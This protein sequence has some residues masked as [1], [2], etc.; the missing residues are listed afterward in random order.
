MTQVKNGANNEG[1]TKNKTFHVFSL[2]VFFMLGGFLAANQILVQNIALA[3]G[4]TKQQMGLMI[5]ALFT[6]STLAVLFIGELGHRMGKRQAAGLTSLAVAAGSIVILLANNLLLVTAGFFI[7][8]SGVGGYESTV[9]SLAADNQGTGA[10]RSLN[11]LQSLFS[12]GAVLTPLLLALLLK[13]S[14]YRPLY[15]AS[16]LFYL[17]STLFYLFYRKID[18]FAVEGIPRKGL[19]F[20]HLVKDPRMILLM[21]AMFIH[22][23]SETALTYWIGSYYASVGLSDLA[24][25]SLSV[26]WF[27]SIVGRLLA[28]RFHSPARIIAPAY[29]LAAGGTALLV[30]LPSA[31]LKLLAMALVGIGF[32]PVY[33]GLTLIGSGLYPTDTAPVF[34]LMVFSA[35]LGGVAFQPLM[36][37][38]VL[39]GNPQGAYWTIAALCAVM[40]ALLA[41]QR[42]KA[43]ESKA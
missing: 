25:L 10:N 1:L 27:S 14:A 34:S 17:L 5:S 40:A 41:A 30:L 26:Y 20:L 12:L 24:A 18:R 31:P 4:A 2:F 39:S 9:M 37:L 13:G 19:T 29:T 23:G 36:G 35:G 3:L 38:F 32:S 7:Y 42:F 6:G 28:S 16:A 43:Q 33:V 21:F 11:I 15:A 22:I 8:G